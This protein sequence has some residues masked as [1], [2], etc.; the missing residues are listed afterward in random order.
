MH[1]VP[2]LA[3]AFANIKVYRILSQTITT[4]KKTFFQGQPARSADNTILSLVLYSSYCSVQMYVLAD[5]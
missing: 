4:K 1:N 2:L 5:Y 3:A